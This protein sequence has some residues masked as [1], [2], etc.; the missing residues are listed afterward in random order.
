MKKTLSDLALSALVLALG[1]APAFADSP[2]W[3]TNCPYSHTNNDDPIVYPG[4]PGRAHTHDF[5]GARTADHASTYSSMVSGPTTCGTPEDKA[6]YW[7]PALYRNGAKIN[8]AWSINGKKVGQKFYYRDGHYTVGATVEPFPPNF[9]MIQGYMHASSVADA[10]ARGA[11][12]GTKMWWGCSDN[13]VG[14]K[15]TSPPDCRTGIL[16]LH[17]TF[18]SCWDGVAVGG[19]AVAAGHVKFPSDKK[20][21]FTHPRRLPVLIQRLE[22]PVGT[23]SSGITLSSGAPYTAHA[24]FWNTWQQPKLNA[25]VADCLNRDVDCGTNP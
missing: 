4:Q 3:I 8:P 12:W 22:Y 11:K 15:Q 21:P 9:R 13:S 20:C 2:G 1:A 16:T 24:D 25:L 18:P 17:V 7:A 6:G 14:G 23:S 10:N 5:F 19:D